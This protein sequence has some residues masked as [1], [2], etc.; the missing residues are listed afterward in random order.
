[1]KHKGILKM[2]VL[3]VT[4][5]IHPSILL[6]QSVEPAAEVQF[7]GVPFADVKGE[8]FGPPNTMGMGLLNG[9]AAFELQ[10]QD[11]MVPK[12][13]F[14]SAMD[15]TNMDFVT[16]VQKVQS[17]PTGT[18]VKLQGTV[19]GVPFQAKVEGGEVKVEGLSLTQAQFNALFDSLQRINGIREVEVEAMVNGVVKEAKFENGKIETKVEANDKSRGRAEDKRHRGESGTS[20]SLNNERAKNEGKDL[21]HDL[22]GPD[23]AVLEGEK[24]GRADRPERLGRDRAERSQKMERMER[25]EKMERMERVERPEHRDR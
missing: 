18:E 25:P 19:D 22:R 7:Q 12:G 9:G 2:L 13:F 5:L 20:A 8:L 6:A 10:A 1:M 21:P 23:R 4:F 3:G 11:I 24:A 16:L 14:T 15:F 17:L